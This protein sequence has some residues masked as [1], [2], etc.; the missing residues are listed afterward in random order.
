MELVAEFAGSV[1]I[2]AGSFRKRCRKPLDASA[3]AYFERYG[4]YP[5][6]D[7]LD[8]ACNHYFVQQNLYAVLLERR[9]GIRLS[10]MWLVQIH[11]ALESY[12][13]IEVPDMREKAALVIDRYASGRPKTMP[14]EGSAV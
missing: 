9:Y 12:I 7:C 2:R 11:P 4:V 8:N 3:G 13:V 5:F 10:S 14:W 6:N 1:R